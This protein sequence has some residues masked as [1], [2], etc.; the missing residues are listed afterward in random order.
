M[1]S[2]FR[3][4]LLRGISAVSSALTTI[5]PPRSPCRSRLHD[6]LVHSAQKIGG[7]VCVLQ[8]LLC[9]GQH[10]T[11]QQAHAR[12]KG[13][14]AQF[15]RES[16]AAPHNSARAFGERFFVETRFG[17]CRCTLCTSNFPNRWVG[18]KYPTKAEDAIMRRCPYL[19]K[20]SR[21]F[22]KNFFRFGCALSEV[23]SSNLRSRSFCSRVRR[24]G[25]STTTVT[26]WSPRLRPLT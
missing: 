17:K 20:A 1:P 2:A 16:G 11:M 6:E 4:I 15:S 7:R 3:P 8:I 10:R 23:A 25:V 24:V 21:S 13:N 18:E 26:Y 5:W 14:T 12:V 9:Q 22:S 19:S